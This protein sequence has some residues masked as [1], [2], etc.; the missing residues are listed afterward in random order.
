LHLQKNNGLAPKTIF[1]TF[2]TFFY[3]THKHNALIYS[4]LLFLGARAILFFY[5]GYQHRF[6]INYNPPLGF[7]FAGFLLKFKPFFDFYGPFCFLNN[8]LPL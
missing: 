7:V 1:F 3:T 2:F 6:V 4:V 5:S 8:F